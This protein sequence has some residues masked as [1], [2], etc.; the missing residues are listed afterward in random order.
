MSAARAMVF[1]RRHAPVAL[2]WSL[3]SACSVSVHK[4]IRRLATEEGHMRLGCG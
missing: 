2:A 1:A 3:E 4:Y